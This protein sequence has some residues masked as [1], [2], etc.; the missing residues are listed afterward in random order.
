MKAFI[1][2]CIFWMSF[3]SILT[4]IGLGLS[5]YPFTREHTAG[6]AVV[7]LVVALGFIAWGI[8]LVTK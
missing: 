8:Y 2:V 5:T 3:R 6:M 1:L 4:F 7:K